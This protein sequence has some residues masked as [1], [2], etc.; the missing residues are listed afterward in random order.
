[1][2]EIENFKKIYNYTPVENNYTVSIHQD[3]HNVKIHQLNLNSGGS[4]M[5]SF[6]ESFSHLS[7]NIYKKQSHC[8]RSA[9]GI[10]FCESE[11]KKII[12]CELKSSGGGVFDS[13]YQQTFSSYIKLCMMMSICDDFDIANYQVFFVFT[14]SDGPELALRRNE[15]EQIEESDRNIYDNIRLS[16][17]KGEKAIFHLNEIP[18]D[19]SFLHRHLINKEIACLLLTSKTDT[20]DVDVNIL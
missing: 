7:D 14:A 20:I 3:G 11:K 13:A 8:N 16:L 9:D 18:H 5:A 17:L 12:I 6:D 4:Y 19:I 1:M 15:I 10:V 2:L